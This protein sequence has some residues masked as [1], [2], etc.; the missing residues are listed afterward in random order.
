MLLNF[1]TGGLSVFCGD[2]RLPSLLTNSICCIYSHIRQVFKERFR[3]PDW[4]VVL[5]V[6]SKC[7]EV[8][9][10]YEFE[11]ITYQVQKLM[12]RLG[13]VRCDIPM[14]SRLGSVRCEIHTVSKLGS[15][16]REKPTVS[17]MYDED[18]SPAAWLNNEVVLY[19]RDALWS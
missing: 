1:N 2:D 17:F 8:K 13:S 7:G 16:R 14:V 15:V 9:G 4:G 3:W 10:R 6:H 19:A 18:I 11:P 12:S 5:Y